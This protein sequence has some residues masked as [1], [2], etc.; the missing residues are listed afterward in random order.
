MRVLTLGPEGSCHENAVMAYLKHHQINS[1]HIEFIYDFVKALEKI[2]SN[3]ADLLI[4]CS[5]HPLVHLVTEKYY[6]EVSIADTFI[7]PTKELV[8]LERLD[9]TQPKTLG[10]VKATEGYL[11]N[12]T[13]GE[14]IYEA[15]KPI[16]GKN[17]LEKKYDAGL[18]HIEYFNQQPD[19][20]RIK[21]NIG[22]VTTT[23]L[24]YSKKSFFEGNLLSVLPK[25]KINEYVACNSI[26]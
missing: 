26:T 3:E 17:L 2:R 14:I 24:V 12:I 1:Y 20:F 8:L 4:Q 13:Y 16:I 9:V 18:T 11:D 19:M 22:E 10:L 23:W 5:A 6:K 25:G 15:S 21:K 7:Y